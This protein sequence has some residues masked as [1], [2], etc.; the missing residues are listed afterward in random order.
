MK[1]SDVITK[2]YNTLKN[3]IKNTD[4]EIYKGFTGEDVFHNC[5]V[6]A[7]SKYGNEEVEEKPTLDYLRKLILTESKF[8][9]RRKNKDILVITDTITE[10]KSTI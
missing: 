1:I 4:T 10:P 9:Y 6:T 7:L 2:H 3:L 5:L 8:S